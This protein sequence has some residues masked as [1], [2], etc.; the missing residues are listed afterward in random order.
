MVSFFISRP[1][2]RFDKF[3]TNTNQP[4][5]LTPN[6]MHLFNEVK[7]TL[8]QRQDELLNLNKQNE[9]LNTLTRTLL[10][11]LNVLLRVSD[12][13]LTYDERKAMKRQTEELCK[14]LDDHFDAEAIAEYQ[15]E[16]IEEG[17]Y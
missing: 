10:E 15:A 11:S 16:G 17:E 12:Q 6:A 5:G 3:N 14:G 8:K 4:T 2:L 1:L 13:P 7:S 9:R